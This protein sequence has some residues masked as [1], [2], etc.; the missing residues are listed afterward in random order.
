M[1]TMVWVVQQNLGLRPL[2]VLHIH[3]SPYTSSGQR[4]RA[5][6]ASQPQKSVT[7]GHNREGGNHEKS[8]RDM[9]WHWRKNIS[10]AVPVK[11]KKNTAKD[12]P[13]TLWKDQLVVFQAKCTNES[14]KIQNHTRHANT[15]QGM[16]DPSLL[17]SAHKE[18]QNQSVNAV[19]CHFDCN[20][21]M[22]SSDLKDG[23]LKQ[24]LIEKKEHSIWYVMLVTIHPVYQVSKVL[25]KVCSR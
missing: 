13:L 12:Q 21:C 18:R 23:L 9:W 22:E 3:I 16:S 15:V 24:Y 4:N 1:V 2:L 17:H 19:H 11:S 8:I 14:Y 20:I 5:S 6:Q 7:L 10:V 25:K